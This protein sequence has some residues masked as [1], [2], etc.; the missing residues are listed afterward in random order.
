MCDK[1]DNCSNFIKNE[2]NSSRCIRLCDRNPDLMGD[3]PDYWIPVK[4][5]SI[6]D[7]GSKDGKDPLTGGF[8]PIEEIDDLPDDYI[9]RRKKKLED[10][11]LTRSERRVIKDELLDAVSLKAHSDSTV[12]V[13]EAYD[14]PRERKT[15]TLKQMRAEIEAK[16]T[17]EVTIA[18][19]EKLN[20]ALNTSQNFKTAQVP[21]RKKRV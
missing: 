3:I 11:S 21:R 7:A 17:S 8:R 4:K 12:V 2:K 9:D 13:E 14:K 19:E 15:M 6:F 20:E 10:E 1:K 5:T 16:K 18:K